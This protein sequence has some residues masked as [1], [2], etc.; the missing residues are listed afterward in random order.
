MVDTELAYKLKKQMRILSEL[1]GSGTELV[2][3]YIP[4]GYPIHET[5][6]RLREEINQ[7][8]NIKSKSTRNNVIGALERI[9]AHLKHFRQTPPNG[10]A[11]F[12]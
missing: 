1:K 5:G 9:I 7:A 4:H 3:V 10:M 12:A 6:N 8:G 2:S 11:V